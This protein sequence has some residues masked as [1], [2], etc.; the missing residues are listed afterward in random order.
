MLGEF[1]AADELGYWFF[2]LFVWNVA[3]VVFV[4]DKC[5]QLGLARR[6]IKLLRSVVWQRC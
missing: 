2:G 1:T 6:A 4:S 3:T 5:A